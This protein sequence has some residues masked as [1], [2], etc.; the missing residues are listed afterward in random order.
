LKDEVAY[1][2][3]ITKLYAQYKATGYVMEDTVFDALMDAK[4]P[5]H[6]IDNI[7]DRLLSMG[8]LV[9]I[10]R[11]AYRDENGEEYDRSQLDYEIIYQEVL[12]LDDQLA[13][14][15]EQ[16]AQNRFLLRRHCHLMRNC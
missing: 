8:V 3:I 16:A 11:D 10:D 6:D 5:L 1:E 2:S 7:L 14:F 13:S 4:I 9:E 15:V 12:L